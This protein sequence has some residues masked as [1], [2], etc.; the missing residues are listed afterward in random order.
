MLALLKL[1]PIRDYFYGVVILAL[2]A[3]LAYVYRHGEI[4]VEKLDAKVAAVAEKKSAVSEVS[5][6]AQENTNAIIYKQAVSVPAVGDLGVECVRH[7]SGSGVVPAS[8]TG[9]AASA[10]VA[11]VNS[12]SGHTFD[13]SGA[14]LTRAHDADAQIAYLQ[15]RV[16]ELEA[17]MN[18]AP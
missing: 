12:G 17:E 9:A 4:H 3:L 16:K 18:S 6:K 15:A 1:V 5:A 8:I 13:P 10:G 7:T 2:L 11:T 14:I